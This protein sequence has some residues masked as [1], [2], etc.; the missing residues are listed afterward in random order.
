MKYLFKFY[1][2]IAWNWPKKWQ[3]PVLTAARGAV[4]SPLW[5]PLWIIYELLKWNWKAKSAKKKVIIPAKFY[6][7]SDWY[8]CHHCEQYTYFLSGRNNFKCQENLRS[9]TISAISLEWS[10]CECSKSHN[11]AENS[12]CDQMCDVNFISCDLTL[13]EN[14]L[15]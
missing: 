11:F 2:Y 14:S 9:Q 10:I 12:W 13:I 5:K 7:Q 1:F 6:L 3:Y 15:K 4:S 8:Q